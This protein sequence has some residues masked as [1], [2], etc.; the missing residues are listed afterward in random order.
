MVLLGTAVLGIAGALGLSILA[1][2]IVP[3][4]YKSSY[5]SVVA[6]ILPWYV[7]AMVPLAV[8]NTLLNNL[9][10]RPASKLLPASCVS[11]LSAGY[12]FALTQLHSS[13]VTVLKTMGV[14]N[15]LLL[16]VCALFTWGIGPRDR[17]AR[18]I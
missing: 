18:D 2:W 9:L 13:L 10:A 3:I 15:V 14:F 1:P 16:V 6:Q 4:I 7:S 17:N 12:L 8:A 11:L 5:V